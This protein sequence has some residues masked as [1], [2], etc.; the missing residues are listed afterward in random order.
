M[1]PESRIVAL[2]KEKGLT[3]AELA[4]RSGVSVR[5]IQRIESG[6][7]TPY[8][9]TLRRIAGALSI[10]AAKLKK[11]SAP[12]STLTL[13]HLSPI[14]GWILPFFQLIAPF[15]VW[16]LYRSAY[17]GMDTHFRDLFAFHALTTLLVLA[18]LALIHFSSP[19]G[20]ILAA[21]TL[22]TCTL[23][24]LWNAYRVSENRRY[25]YLN[26]SKLKNNNTVL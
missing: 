18:G 13:L 12:A 17:S 5:T 20:Y 26:L 11:P 15:A 8:D 25:R 6:G 16:L 23:L 21:G 9:D 1:K 7:V 3:Q 19:V 22:L 14:I 24:T 10:E 2:R 4:E